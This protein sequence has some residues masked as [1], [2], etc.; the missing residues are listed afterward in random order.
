MAKPDVKFTDNRR[1]V[2][3]QM[4]SNINRALTALG[5]KGVELTV[6]KMQ[7][8]YGRPIWLSGDL[9]RSITKEERP[10]DKAVDIGSN[11]EYAPWVHEG[12][13]RMKGRPFLKDALL[14]GRGAL[15]E[16]GEKYL[17]DGFKG[18]GVSKGNR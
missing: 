13:S 9:Q 4:G 11:V 1:A 10:E 14:D 3:S 17:G 5:L 12:T 16:I 2:K 15:N 6:S 7:S 8:G 18:V